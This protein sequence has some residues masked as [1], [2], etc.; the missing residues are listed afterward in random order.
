MVCPNRCLILHPGIADDLKEEY[1][2]LYRHALTVYENKHRQVPGHQHF[3][4]GLIYVFTQ[5]ENQRSVA[6]VGNSAASSDRRRHKGFAS[7]IHSPPVV[8]FDTFVRKPPPSDTSPMFGTPKILSTVRALGCDIKTPGRI[9]L[10][11][12]KASH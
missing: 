3:G 7:L 2:F 6:N 10:L 8:Y 4:N 9:T 11:Y 12:R 5:G 1:L